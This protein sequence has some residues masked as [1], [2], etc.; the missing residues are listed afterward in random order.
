MKRAPNGNEIFHHLFPNIFSLLCYIFVL[1][2]WTKCSMW[3][4]VAFTCLSCMYNCEHVGE[5]N[6]RFYFWWIFIC[7]ICGPY[8]IYWK[9]H[10]TVKRGRLRGYIC[11]SSKSL[12]P[13]TSIL[14]SLKQTPKLKSLTERSQNVLNEPMDFLKNRESFTKAV[15]FRSK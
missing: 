11:L 8:E 10:V 9:A 5:R 4:N 6:Y 7:V 14:E 12:D 3:T 15:N 13:P 2:N 1:P